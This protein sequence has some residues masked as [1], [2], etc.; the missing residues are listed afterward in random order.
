MSVSTCTFSRTQMYTPGDSPQCPRRSCTPAPRHPSE[1]E[2]PRGKKPFLLRRKIMFPGNTHCPLS[3]G[4]P[5]IQQTPQ[6][7]W[8]PSPPPLPSTR[9]SEM[10]TSVSKA[11]FTQLRNGKTI[12]PQLRSGTGT[13]A[14][15]VDQGNTFRNMKLPA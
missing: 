8:L 13:T 1:E 3:W 15:P 10:A 12:F 2:D 7:C 11:Q 14:T 9:Y 6:I 4:S 5:S